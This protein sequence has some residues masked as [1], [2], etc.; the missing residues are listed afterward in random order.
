MPWRKASTHEQ[1]F[2]TAIAPASEGYVA[3]MTLLEAVERFVADEVLPEVEAWDEHDVL[4]ER[5][6]Q[7]LRELGLPGAMVPE[8]YGGA[9]LSV[10]ELVPVWRA[11]SRGW[12]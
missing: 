11:L 6:E 8:A 3:R 2:V 9:G 10:T 5:A 1:G 7:R 12:I 4:P